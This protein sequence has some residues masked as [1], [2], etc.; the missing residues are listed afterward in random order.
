VSEAITAYYLGRDDTTYTLY[1]ST[2]PIISPPSDG[3]YLFN[4]V[5]LKQLTNN[6][7]FSAVK[8]YGALFFYCGSMFFF[9]ILL[10]EIVYEREHKLRQGMRMMGLKSSMYW[11]AWF[12]ES[13]VFNI[14]STL[15]IICVGM[16]LSLSLSLSLSLCVC[17]SL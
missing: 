10:Y 7:S 17:V 12:I 11:L 4:P 8:S 6:L 14:I 2:Y 13:Q 3:S 1:T 5:F 9:I 16:F 15:L